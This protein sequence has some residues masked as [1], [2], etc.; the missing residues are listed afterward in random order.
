MEWCPSPEGA[1]VGSSRSA[2]GGGAAGGCSRGRCSRGGPLRCWRLVPVPVPAAVVSEGHAGRWCPSHL[3][4]LW[5]PS[6][7]AA[8]G[9]LAAGRRP[10]AGPSGPPAWPPPVF[11]TSTSTTS[12]TWTTQQTGVNRHRSAD[13]GQHTRQET[14]SGDTGQQTQVNRHR[15]ADTG[16]HTRQETGSGD[17]GQQTQVSRQGQGTQVSRHRSADRVRGHR[18]ADTGQQT[19]VSRQGQGTTGQQTQVNRHRSADTG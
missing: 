3:Q 17:T 1:A 14:G 15:S 4:V 10:A 16:Q 5:C 13:T 6:F 12:R 11:C 2:G 19:Q 9:G 18:S 8:S 7:P